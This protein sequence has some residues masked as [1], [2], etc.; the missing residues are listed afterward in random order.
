MKSVASSAA[1]AE[2]GALFK[3]A[4]EGRIIRLTLKD[5]DHP[6]PPTPMHCDNT[7][8]A[9]IANGSVKRQH[10][11]AMEM[12]YFYIYDQ[13]KNGEFDVILNPGKENMGDYA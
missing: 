1:E 2:L 7:T 8:A 12:Q 3:N 4:K 13:V 9:G 6:Q 5:L 11:R 10:S